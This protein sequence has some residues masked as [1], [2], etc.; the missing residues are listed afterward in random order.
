MRFTFATSLI[1]LSCAPCY[2]VEPSFKN[3]PDFRTTEEILNEIHDIK[4]TNCANEIFIQSLIE[5][6]DEISDTAPENEM[7]VWAQQT[8]Q[9]TETL[10]QILECPEIQHISDDTTI[11]FTPI[12]YKFNNGRHIT[13]NYS[14]QPKI[15]KQKI[16]ASTKR[17]LPNGNVSPNLMDNT[18]GSKYTNTEP[19]WYAIMVVQ[20]DSLS[21]YIGPDKNNI[22]SMKYIND[23][24]DKIYPNG[25]FCTSK[26]AIANNKDTIN[27][28]VRRI[29]DVK[30][31]SND[32]YVAGDVNL[33]WVMY[34]EIAADVIITVATMGT[35]EI[36]MA[37]LKGVRATKTA[38]NL[39][40]SMKSL[41]KL[42]DVKKYKDITQQIT[43]QTNNI[44]KIDKNIKNAEQY[45]KV[46][47]NIESAK[48][49]GKDVSRYEKQATEIFK[50]AKEID[51]GITVEQLKNAETLKN[52]RKSLQESV[53]TLKQ[54]ADKIASESKDVKLY[55]ESANAFSDVMNYRRNLKSFRRPQ[56]GNFITKPLKQTWAYAKSAHAINNGAKMMTKAGK[57]ARA[58]MSS[59]STK[60]KS[61]LMDETLKHGARL[62]RFERDAGILYGAVS[63]IGDMYDKTSATSK[64]FSNGI[65][66]KPLCLLSADDLEGQ[67]NKVNYGM[68]LMWVGDSTDTSED[69]VAYLQA[70]DF[71]SKF[72]YALDEYQDENG[73]NCNV[74]IYVVR[75]IIRLDETNPDNPSGELFYLFTNEIPWSTAEQFDANVPNKNEWERMQ[76][77]L[78]NT[79]PEYKYHKPAQDIHEQ[80]AD[81]I[82][83]NEHPSESENMNENISE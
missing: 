30:D 41:S 72:F 28:V 22:L 2:C 17:N 64:E 59:R 42:D 25:Y 70:M 77:E 71:A 75:P 66:F 54:D 74:D 76:I 56:T 23:N 82:L 73:V 1:I 33:E 80:V 11:S 69:D 32:Y 29:V 3:N 15:L 50:N 57:T 83:T 45:E 78:L 60:I 61:W 20:H 48:R 36:A 27:E 19:A 47:K 26:S 37:G 58:G 7:R 6:A 65:E 46:L 12:V 31:D 53:Q 24:I 68:W 14:T 8:I 35:G 34:A 43:R 67:E 81:T 51:S 9:N 55:Q 40:Q 21:E 52:N 49:A 62:A 13:I 18:D 79:D 4:P 10:K 63:F 38:R 5:H 39:A 44:A 16:M